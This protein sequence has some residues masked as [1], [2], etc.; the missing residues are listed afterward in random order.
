MYG[1]DNL[2]AEDKK[3]FGKFQLIG[4]LTC[5]HALT[6]YTYPCF[7]EHTLEGVVLGAPLDA[8]GGGYNTGLYELHKDYKG[9]KAS[10]VVVKCMP[11]SID[12]TIWGE[13]K[14]L[15]AV[16]YFIDSGMLSMPQ[17]KG[18]PTP[19][20]LMKKIPGVI[21]AETPLWNN[22]RTQRLK[23]VDDLK[24]KVKAEVVAWAVDKKILVR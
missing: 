17:H 23:L 21:P 8:N 12:D 4:L 1:S 14:A 6:N 22:G 7:I 20:I 10:D 13:V 9:H 24:P 16:D 5:S 11:E 15:K 3:A 19:V 18:K 2:N